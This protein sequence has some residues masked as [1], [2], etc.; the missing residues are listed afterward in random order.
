VEGITFPI[1]CKVTLAYAT[2]V[3]DPFR[4]WDAADFW[5]AD[6]EAY[7]KAESAITKLSA[8]LNRLEFQMENPASSLRVTGFDSQRQLA[9]RVKFEEVSNG[10]DNPDD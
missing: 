6:N 4:L 10:S 3:G 2:S 7:P 8:E 9:I 5:V 1:Q